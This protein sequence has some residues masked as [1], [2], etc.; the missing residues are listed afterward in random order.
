M[1]RAGDP[2]VYSSKPNRRA[3]IYPIRQTVPGP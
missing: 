1:N 2:G 3:G